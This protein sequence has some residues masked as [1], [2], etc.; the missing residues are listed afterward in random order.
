MDEDKEK[1]WGDGLD[2]RFP[3]NNPFT[4]WEAYCYLRDVGLLDHKHNTGT[5]YNFL[6]TKSGF[7]G[8]KK[9]GIM[10]WRKKAGINNHP[11]TN[12]QGKSVQEITSAGHYHAWMEKND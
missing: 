4:T 12:S 6:K 9:R 7:K 11:V 1:E 5:V 3:D 8:E 10:F 2:A